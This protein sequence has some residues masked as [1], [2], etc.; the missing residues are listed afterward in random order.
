MEELP[1]RFREATGVETRDILERWLAP[2][3]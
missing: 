3:E 2:L 1:V